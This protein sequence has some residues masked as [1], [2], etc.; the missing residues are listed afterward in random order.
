ME[1]HAYLILAHTNMDQLAILLSLLDDIRNDIFLHIDAKTGTY[2]RE[3]LTA[4]VSKSGFF[5]LEDRVPVEWG[6]YSSV[7]AKLKLL[8]AASARGPYVFY[9]LIS[10]MD[11]PVKSQDEIH[12][13]FDSHRDREFIHFEYGKH[14]YS[15]RY[16]YYYDFLEG[17][18]RPKGKLSKILIRLRASVQGIR[19]IDRTRKYPDIV[20][21]KG[22]NWFSV[23][24][25]FVKEVISRKDW[26]YDAFH[27]TY[28]TDECVIQTIA[29]NSKFRDRIYDSSETSDQ[30]AVMRLIDW[31][32]GHPYVFRREDFDM[33][34]Q[35][36]Y[37]FARK[38]DM[39]VD[40]EIIFRISAYLTDRK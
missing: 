11:L 32:R 13:F 31:E 36:D 34:I 10:G 14:D 3:S 40:A 7:E 25:P 20:F 24:D 29:Y 17:R 27:A 4:A 39:T 19:R 22:S 38:F 30:H 15:Y 21:R 37:L 28:C 26:I 23:T 5:I 33:L 9:H 35:S 12:R 8:E 16:K 1:K 18:P 2:D 6:C